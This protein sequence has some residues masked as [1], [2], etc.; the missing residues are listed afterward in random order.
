MVV[1][2]DSGVVLV[3]M[4]SE[5]LVLVMVFWVVVVEVAV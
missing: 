5:L 3:L 4:L 2:V 1:M